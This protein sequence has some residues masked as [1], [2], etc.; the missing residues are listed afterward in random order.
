MDRI[1]GSQTV[2]NALREKRLEGLCG[3]VG[4]NYEL[5]FVLLGTLLRLCTILRPFHTCC[6]TRVRSESLLH[7]RVS[8]YLKA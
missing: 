4:I 8:V 6:L 2:S 3:H 5:K 7:Q 1:G